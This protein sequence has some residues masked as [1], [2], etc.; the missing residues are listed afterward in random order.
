MGRA[1]S[2]ADLHSINDV[3]CFGKLKMA[4]D[5]AVKASDQ[6]RFFQEGQSWEADRQAQYLKSE[7]RAWLVAVAATVVAVLAVGGMAFLAPLKRVV[8]LVFTVDQATGNVEVVH[9]VDD[10][11][12]VGY[13]ELMD[14]HWA[15]KYVVARESYN[16]RLLQHDY[17]TVLTLSADTVAREYARIFD[18]ANARDKKLGNSVEMKVKVVSVS[19][20]ND[21]VGPKAVVRFERTTRNLAA[22]GV[23]APQYF[24][25]TLAFSYQPS[26]TGKERDLIANPLGYK[27]VGYR[28]DAEMAPTVTSVSASNTVDQP[29]EAVPAVQEA[30]GTASAA[31]RITPAPNVDAVG[32]QR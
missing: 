27:V 5:K 11:T 12:I 14:K 15:A 31:G 7:R 4:N 6:Q 21:P 17:D 1:R 18:G 23:G 16:Y 32:G 2:A 19:L 25:A 28:V 24:V 9:A 29:L 10:R 3:Q 30:Q 26:M 22:D 13:Q 8:P 20:D